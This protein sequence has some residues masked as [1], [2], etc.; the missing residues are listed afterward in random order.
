[1]DLQ[2]A[3]SFSHDVTFYYVFYAVIRSPKL[4]YEPIVITDKSSQLSQKI[5]VYLQG[6]PQRWQI[7]YHSR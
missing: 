1:M 3:V 7:F 5:I 4:V 6:L 2:S